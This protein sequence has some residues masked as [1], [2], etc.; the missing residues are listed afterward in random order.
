MLE[1]GLILIFL[2]RFIY[3]DPLFHSPSQVE[4]GIPQGSVL[5]SALFLFMLM[6]LFL[7]LQANKKAYCRLSYPE[8]FHA[9]KCRSPST[10]GNVLVAI[11]DGS[12]IGSAVRTEQEIGIKLGYCLREYF[13]GLMLIVSQVFKACPQLEIFLSRDSNSGPSDYYVWFMGVFLDEN[14][15]LTHHISQINKKISRNLGILRKFKDIFPGLIIKIMFFQPYVTHFAL[16]YG[17]QHFLPFGYHSLGYI[18][19]QGALTLIR[20]VLLINRC[21]IR[22]HFIL[23]HLCLS[24]FF[25]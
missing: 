10:R 13:C 23:F 14:F 4:F 17:C 3:V 20:I 15:S 19:K 22:I 5:R 1:L 7:W 18:T 11:A 6:I 8:S 12:T 21:L 25:N 9:N 16:L 24:F 2:I